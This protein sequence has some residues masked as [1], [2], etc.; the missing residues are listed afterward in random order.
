MMSDVPAC[1]ARGPNRPCLPVPKRLDVTYREQLCQERLTGATS[2]PLREHGRGD[3][4]HHS[5]REERTVAEPHDTLTAIGRY[6][7]A[8]VIRHGHP[9]SQALT[10]RDVDEPRYT[11]CGRSSPS[12]THRLRP[13]HHR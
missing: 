1:A 3:S 10:Q 6:Q 12:P 7:S 13:A 11:D 5:L 2:P 8:G 4:R 9:G